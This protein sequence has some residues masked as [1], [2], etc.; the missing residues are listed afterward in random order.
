MEPIILVLDPEGSAPRRLWIQGI[1]FALLGL[2]NLVQAFL[3]DN[4]FRLVNFVVGIVFISY[5]IVYPMM[6]RPKLATFD[7]RGLTWSVKRKRNLSLTWNQIAYIEAPTLHFHI[8]TKNSEQF[9]IELGNLTYEQ[10]KTLK[11]RIIDL[12]RSHGVDVRLI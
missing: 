2:S 8:H 5:G 4:H 10:H 3:F 7:E 9:T 11:P 12:A 1:L 6:F